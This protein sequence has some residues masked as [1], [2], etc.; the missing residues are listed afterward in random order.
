VGSRRLMN[1]SAKEIRLIRP[2]DK[3]E[4]RFVLRQVL[5]TLLKVH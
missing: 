2:D 1:C 3:L 5:R 4:V